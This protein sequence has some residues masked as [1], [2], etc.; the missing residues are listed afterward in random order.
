MS[1]G[2]TVHIHDGATITLHGSQEAELYDIL[3][4]M[5]EADLDDSDT[6]VILDDKATVMRDKTGVNIKL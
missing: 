1:S 6:S 2:I 4:N 3:N 5:T